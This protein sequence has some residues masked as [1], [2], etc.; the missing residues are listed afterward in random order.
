MARVL[1]IDDEPTLRATLRDM[2]EDDGYDVLDAPDGE[3]GLVLLRH[4]AV[5]VV[6]TDIMMP[7][8]EGLETIQEIKQAHPTA[9]IVAMSG[10]GT[11]GNLSYLNIADKLGAH[12]VLAKPFARQDLLSA[13]QKVLADRPA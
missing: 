9:R 8:K 3:K 7:E 12:H 2:L 13:L 6:L 5:D 10:G 1:I 4:N 11:T